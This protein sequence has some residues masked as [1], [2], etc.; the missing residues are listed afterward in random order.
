M[1]W[2]T[3]SAALIAASSLQSLARSCAANALRSASTRDGG[4]ARTTERARLTDAERLLLSLSDDERLTLR[5]ITLRTGYAYG[6][7]RRIIASAR[8]KR[9]YETKG[10]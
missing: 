4:M 2:P 1:T 6:S 5:E 3:I 8:R 9:G 7:V 10:R